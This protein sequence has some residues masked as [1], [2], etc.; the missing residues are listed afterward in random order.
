MPGKRLDLQT[1]LM[2]YS[3]GYADKV[4]IYVDT[5]EQASS[6]VLRLKET[7]ALIQVKQL[8][9]GDYVLSDDIVVERKTVEDFLGSVIDGRLFNQLTTMSSNYSAPLIILEGNPQELFTTRNIHENAIRGILASIALNYHIPILYAADEEE[10]VKYLYQIAKR[11]QLGKD[12]EI[13]LRVGRKGLTA[14]A[15]QQFVLE[16]FPMVGPGLAKALLKKFGSI[17]TI[18]NATQKELQEAEKMGPKKAKKIHEVLNTYYK[19]EE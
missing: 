6:I 14:Q 8:E 5:R 17:R 1:T 16:G 3:E 18:V 10:T 12:N 13:R 2:K 9:V 4:I 7:G 19:E 11:E 15:Q